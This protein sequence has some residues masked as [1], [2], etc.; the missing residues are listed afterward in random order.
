MR[1]FKGLML[2]GKLT[3]AAA[4]LSIVP[5]VL[6]GVIIGQQGINSGRDVVYKEEQ[7]K[8]DSVL[9]SRKEAIEDYLGTIR[10]QVITLSNDKMTVDALAVFTS[11]FKTFRKEA[12]ISDHDTEMLRSKLAN[13]YKNDFSRTYRDANHG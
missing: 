10:D 5:V 1:L 13:Y 7:S 12:G 4:A 9:Q 8:L 6:A 11:D 2:K 3:V